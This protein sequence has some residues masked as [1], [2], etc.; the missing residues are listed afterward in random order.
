MMAI[1]DRTDVEAS[2]PYVETWRKMERKT[3]VMVM[4]LEKPEFQESSKEISAG[5]GIAGI[6]NMRMLAFG[7]SFKEA[8]EMGM[9]L[10]FK[11]PSSAHDFFGP[12]KGKVAFAK[13]ALGEFKKGIK[14]EKQIYLFD[15]LSKAVEASKF[16]QVQSSLLCE[17]VCNE[18]VSYLLTIARQLPSGSTGENRPSK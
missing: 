4:D 17:T 5:L 9:T 15:A 7:A 10:Q 2:V 11:S 12:V 8:I 1:M 14:D 18:S 13:L 3:L 6:E 16:R